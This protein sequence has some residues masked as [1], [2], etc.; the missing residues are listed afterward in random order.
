MGAE[1]VSTW[2]RIMTS[3]RVRVT[4]ATMVIVAVALV[5][6]SVLLVRATERRLTHAVRQEAEQAVDRGAVVIQS[7]AMPTGPVPV[8]EPFG[9][10]VVETVGE[11][12]TGGSPALP[13][14][15]PSVGPGEDVVV[16]Q[17]VNGVPVLV[18]VR[19]VSTERGSIVIFAAA[20]LTEVRRSVDWLRHL[21]WVAVPLLVLA[22]GAA[23]WWLVGRALRPVER[24][25]REVDDIRHRTLHRRLPEQGGT[26]E[27][28]RLT[29][30]LNDML[31]RLEVSADRQR[32]FISDA[33]HELRSPLTTIRAAVEVADAGNGAALDWT[34]VSSAVLGETDRLEALVAELLLLARLDEE[35]T[36]AP[37]AEEV[38]VDDI[39][40][41]E[42][43]RV[44][45]RVAIVD[46][47]GVGAV[48]CAGDRRQLTLLVR[49]LL[50]N[51]ARHARIRVAVATRTDGSRL[52]L[53]VADDGPGVAP[54]DRD[55]IFERFTRLDEG[56]GR[57]T[58]GAGLGLALV[59]AVAER[60]AGAVTVTDGPL[61]GASFVVTLPTCGAA[62]PPEA[63]AQPAVG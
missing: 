35:S 33:S 40:L 46:V 58:G 45:P 51:A 54:A 15:L 47:S 44:R 2:R 9:S 27:I 5:A 43:T 31:D 22:V 60:H 8:A 50:D 34:G 18:A 13:L 14:Q 53:T 61:G 3:V 20:R 1:R 16:E 48:R 10:P 23:A 11:A 17:N 25:R 55:A 28:A 24:L 49:N 6:T 37:P 32:R 19:N 30:T 36:A 41:E 26:D 21:L 56:R 57:G 29:G 62:S 59:R 12:S 39:V 7:K 52:V 63:V 4:A 38:D 42:A